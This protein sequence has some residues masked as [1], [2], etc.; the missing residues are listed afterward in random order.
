MAKIEIYIPTVFHWEG[1]FVDDKLDRGG[2]TNMGVT[3]STWKNMG[4]DKD[5]DGDI[6]VADL[7][8]IT[9]EDVIGIIR[10][11]AWDPW[12][13]DE[14]KSQSIANVVA[15]W[16]WGSGKWGKIIPQRLLNVKPDGVIGP[17]TIAAINAVDSK[18][19]FDKLQNERKTFVENIVKNDPT[20]VRFIKGWLNRINSFKF[21]D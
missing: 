5:H 19:F 8:L 18:Y 2:A 11:F 17:V 14:I 16:V 20:Q 7:K 12:K 6:D 10:R 4:Y 3:I 21:I 9:K 15:D 13:A 1:K